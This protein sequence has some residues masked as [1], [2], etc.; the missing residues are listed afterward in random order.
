[1]PDDPRR[2]VLADLVSGLVAGLMEQAAAY[3]RAAR[4]VTGVLRQSLVDLYRAMQAEIAA[5][6]PLARDPRRHAAAPP[7]PSGPERPW[8]VILGRR[9]RRSGPSSGWRGSSP[10]WRGTPHTGL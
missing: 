9:F 2:L 7:P 6:T 8:G 10:P 4:R 3:E 1:V 5:L